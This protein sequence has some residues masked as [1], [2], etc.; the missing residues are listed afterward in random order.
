MR[1]LTKTTPPDAC[2]SSNGV[3]R[4]GEP[5][6]FVAVGVTAWKPMEFLYTVGTDT[7]WKLL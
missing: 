2:A 4:S 1:E 6:Q 7:Q 3:R 5:Q